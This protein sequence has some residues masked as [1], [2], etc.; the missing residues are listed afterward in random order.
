MDY[1]LAVEASRLHSEIV[2]L[3]GGAQSR[4]SPRPMS[5]AGGWK[6]TV[7]IQG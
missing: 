7:G 1:S 6:W 3:V 4:S 2:Y 5:V